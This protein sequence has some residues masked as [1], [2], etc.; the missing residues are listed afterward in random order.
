MIVDLA[1]IVGAPHVSNRDADRLAYSRDSWTRDLLLLRAGQVPAAPSCVVWPGTAE[2][3][4]EVLS[5]AQTHGVPVVP[6][7]T[8]ASVVGGARP[9]AGG[10]VLDLK[11]MRALRKLDEINLVVEV[12]AG[13]IGERLERR[14][15]Q[16]GYTLGHFPASIPCSTLGGWLATR[17]AGYMSTR[18]GK[19]EDMA[20]GLEV[21]TPG[22]VRTT[23]SKPRPTGGIDFN[24]MIMGSEGTLG[25]ITA[26]HLRIRP[27]PASRSF[28]GMRFNSVQAGV[29]AL[30]QIMQAGL[31]PSIL[32]LYDGV[33]TWV[34]LVPGAADRW[35]ETRLLDPLTD[36][37]QL[38]F[39]SLAQRVPGL[40]ASGRI[41][42][43][44]RKTLLQTT[45]R[46]VMGAP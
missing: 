24:A 14:L 42:Q 29:E 28:A 16:H 46:T 45:V 8:G 44:F 33:D 31:R 5:M 15:N 30:R 40:N 26:A 2:E 32:R 39:D 36:R 12:E 41:A 9:S 43:R 18:Y 37:A 23:I 13:I 38:V 35:D 4:S 17:S 1:R 22:R 21:V 27:L 7:G 6:Y 20:L 11:R 34:G 19:I 3:V 10:I 25:A